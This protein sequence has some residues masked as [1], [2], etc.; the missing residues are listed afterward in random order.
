MLRLWALLI[1][2]LCPSWTLAAVTSNVHTSGNTGGSAATSLTISVTIAAGSNTNLYVC[3]GDNAGTLGTMST[4]AWNTSE[5]L[6]KITEIDASDVWGAS[7]WRL[8]APTTGT[9]NV[10]I[11]PS[12]SVNMAAA[13]IALNGVDQTTSERTQSTATLSDNT[14][15]GVTVTVVN[16]QNGDYVID[17]VGRRQL[18]NDTMTVGA[19]QTMLEDNRANGF[20][21][22]GV[23]LS[24]EAAT[25]ANTVM[26]WSYSGTNLS[27]ATIGIPIVAASGGGAAETF[28]FRRR[29]QV[30]P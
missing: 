24:T 18:E 15:T 13:V 9:H 8:K 2:L 12:S 7:L 17:C 21:D 10:V 27:Y 16:S 14:G 25:G 23:L 4:V 5:S 19:G 3:V 28:G 20:N 22:V 1:L 30:Q 29:L 6:T 11:T 26:S